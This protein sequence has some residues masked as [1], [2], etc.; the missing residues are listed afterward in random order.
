MK[1]ACIKIVILFSS[2]CFSEALLSQDVISDTSG[3]EPFSIKLEGSAFFRNN[4]Y[5]NTVTEGY[6][7]PGWYFSPE[8][9]WKPDSKTAISFG[10][11]VLQFSGS[12]HKT[13]PELRFSVGRL[14]DKNTTLYA[15]SLPGSDKH[16]LSDPVFAHERFYTDKPENG[17]ELLYKNSFLKSDTWI[18]WKNFIYKGDTT[19]E[20][21]TAG[22]TIRLSFN[23]AGGKVKTEIPVSALFNHW[24]GQISNYSS[25][26]IT[27]V[28]FTGGIRS[29]FLYSGKDNHL[30]F[31]EYT[32]FIFKELTKKGDFG[33]TSGNGNWFRC[34]IRSGM[35][36]ATAGY[37]KSHNYYSPLGNPIYGSVP[38]FDSGL[39][40]PDR[41][42]VTFST[43]LNYL[44]HRMFSL[45][46]ALEGFYDTV[47]GRLDNSVTLRLST[48]S[49]YHPGKLLRVP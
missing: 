25:H 48:F 28:N 20:H 45:S 49:I 17:I 27:T 14:L 21:F 12:D 36:E 16:D 3:F 19:R 42:M 15:G 18:D 34:G 40:T 30:V 1:T 2:F 11:H 46:L 23:R 41:K 10:I 38:D 5:F 44:P 47:T 22:Q 31:A 6:T 32:G 4:E 43:A 37:W 24:G 13:K 35:L 8:F 33:V 7:L 9:E 39:L 29:E 26:V